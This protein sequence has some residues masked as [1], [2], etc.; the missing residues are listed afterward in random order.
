MTSYFGTSDSSFSGMGVCRV[1]NTLAAV[2][3]ILIYRRA[4]FFEH[5]CYRLDDRRLALIFSSISFSNALAL[6]ATLLTLT[7][8]GGGLSSLELTASGKP[9]SQFWVYGIVKRDAVTI[10][11]V[12]N[13]DYR[14]ET[15]FAPRYETRTY[16]LQKLCALDLFQNYWARR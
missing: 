6:F 2:Q 11:N 5:F 7:A 8:L 3:C 4:E 10:H 13:F 15:D 1:W 9:N 16:D 14:T 12:R